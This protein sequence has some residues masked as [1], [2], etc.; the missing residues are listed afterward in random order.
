MVWDQVVHSITAVHSWK[1]FL[2]LS[3]M[4]IELQRP[5]AYIAMLIVHSRV[6]LTRCNLRK[7]LLGT[8]YVTSPL[9]GT[10]DKK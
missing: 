9:P 10:G 5:L 6:K 4:N 8:H 3:E 2:S 1:T 7:P